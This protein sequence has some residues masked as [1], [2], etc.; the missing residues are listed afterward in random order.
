MTLV[1][2]REHLPHVCVCARA[3]GSGGQTRRNE[4]VLPVPC[5]RQRSLSSSWDVFELDKRINYFDLYSYILIRNSLLTCNVFTTTKFMCGVDAVLLLLYS[6]FPVLLSMSFMFH[7]KST[8]LSAPVMKLKNN[9]LCTSYQW[10]V[11]VTVRSDNLHHCLFWKWI[12]LIGGQ[13]S[14]DTS[15]ILHFMNTVI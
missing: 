10:S 8:I 7:T 12:W 9:Y 11:I 15:E 6:Y 4:S 1:R 13:C 3:N 5:S 14:K 2:Q